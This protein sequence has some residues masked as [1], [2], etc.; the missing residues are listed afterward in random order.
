MLHEKVSRL[1]LP[2]V[3]GGFAGTLAIVRP[4]GADFNWA[5]LF[6]VCVVKASAGFQLLTSRM[7]RTED[8]MNM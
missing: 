7:T 1:R 6:P 5:L 8:P 3:A 2:P 4:Q